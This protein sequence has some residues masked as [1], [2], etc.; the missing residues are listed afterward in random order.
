MSLG[1]VMLLTCSAA[2]ILTCIAMALLAW[3]SQP[4]KSFRAGR[5]QRIDAVLKELQTGDLKL[6]VRAL[7]VERAARRSSILQVWPAVQQMRPP[8]IL[9]PSISTCFPACVSGDIQRCK[10]TCKAEGMLCA[11]I[12]VAT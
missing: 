1:K 4:V 5:V 3:Q 8:D 6:R 11:C 7:E 2:V 10:C 12:S 9:M